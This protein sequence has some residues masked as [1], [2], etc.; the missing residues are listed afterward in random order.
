MC[1]IRYVSFSVFWACVGLSMSTKQNE[2]VV[3]NRLIEHLGELRRAEN[4]LCT[5]VEDAAQNLRNLRMQLSATTARRRKAKRILSQRQGVVT[6]Y[7]DPEKT[8]PILA[9]KG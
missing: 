1:E 3:T 6:E 4:T 9:C 5:Q 7:I 8:E 2:T